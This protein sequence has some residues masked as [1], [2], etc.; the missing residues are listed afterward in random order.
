MTGRADFGGVDHGG[1][2]AVA[3]VP[4]PVAAP[5]TSALAPDFKAKS[6]P[7]RRLASPLLSLAAAA[8][9][10]S[11]AT[12]CDPRLPYVR[13]QEELVSVPPVID[14][15][16]VFPP[17]GTVPVEVLIGEQCISESTF[18][19]DRVIDADLAVDDQ[20]AF[21]WRIVARTDN[22]EAPPN[23]V[24]GGL[25]TNNGEATGTP[26]SISPFTVNREQLEGDFFNL[27]DDMI[28]LTH[29]IEV[30][31]TDGAF[32]P[33]VDSLELADPTAGSSFFYWLFTLDDQ[34]C[35]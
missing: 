26:V 2:V 27:V 20:L 4:R 32:G 11:V 14:L 35:G 33:D 28:G 12:G 15:A 16:S 10:L 3:S 13:P 23:T 21:R 25:A 9:A 30:R 17:P 34:P 5:D 6:S 7:R 19:V 24:F 8:L 29:R 22:G 31:V 18:R 1:A